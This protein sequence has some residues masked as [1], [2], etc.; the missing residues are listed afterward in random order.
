MEQI[1]GF[2]P[3]LVQFGQGFQR[4]FAVAQPRLRPHFQQGVQKGVVPL[5]GKSVNLTLGGGKV[6]FRNVIGDD[7]QRR[8]QGIG[9]RFQFADGI[10]ESVVHAPFDR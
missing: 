6:P 10:G 1:Q 9:R 3:L 2:Q 4:F 5:G 8:Q 7:H